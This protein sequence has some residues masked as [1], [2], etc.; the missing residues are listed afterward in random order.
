[1]TPLSIVPAS[2]GVVSG[3]SPS[4]DGQVWVL[5][6]SKRVKTLSSIR[7]RDGKVVRLLPASADATSVATSPT[8]TLGV[9]IATTRSGAI[10]FRDARTGRVLRTVALDAPVHALAAGSDGTTFYALN[11]TRKVE[12]VSVVNAQNGQVAKTVP[13]PAAA[14]AVQPTPDQSSIYLL[15][16]LGGIVQV[17]LA[18]RRTLAE[19]G[20]N[21]IGVAL[22]MAPSGRTLFVLGGP[23]DTRGV[24]LIDLATDSQRTSVP[25]AADSVA[26]ASG[27]DDRTVFAYVGNP[28]VGNLQVIPLPGG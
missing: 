12:S 16:E 23:R 7:I 17:S 21:Q 22:A 11:G 25:A 6:G 13:A 26:I 9:G 20:L 15:S 27:L 3:T 1:V 4:T 10:E 24:S 2:A 14:V 28:T 5:A 18:T 8:G 19:F